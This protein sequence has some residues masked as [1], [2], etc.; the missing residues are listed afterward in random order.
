MIRRLA[1]PGLVTVLVVGS[2]L[3]CGSSGGPGGDGASVGGTGPG[4]NAGGSGVGSGSSTGGSFVPGDDEDDGLA[5][6]SGGDLSGAGGTIFNGGTQVLTPDQVLELT[7]SECAGFNDTP[8]VFLPTLQLVV[9]Q[10]MS[11]NDPPCTTTGSGGGSGAGGGT[12]AGGGFGMPGGGCTTGGMYTSEPREGSKWLMSVPPMI[13]ALDA[14]P[15]EMSVGMLLFPTADSTRGGAECVSADS[16]TP[17][18]VLGAPGSAQRTA[19]ASALNDALLVYNTPTH[20]AY[21]FG[22]TESLLPYEGDGAKFMILLTD[23]APTQALG[24]GAPMGSSTS[25]T[26]PIL[27][28]IAE[29]AAQGI[30]TYILGSPGSEMNGQ[31]GED[32]RP[33]LSEAAKLGGTGPDG[34]QIDAAPYC[35][36]DMSASPDFATALADALGQV[37]T[38]V[39]DACTFKIPDDIGSNTETF[40]VG[41]TNL[42]IKKGDGSHVLILRDDSPGDCTEGWT[43]NGDQIVLCGTT[44]DSYKADASAEVTLSFGCNAIQPIPA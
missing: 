32:M 9:D 23:G 5:V 15:D 1:Y 34:C 38:G 40:D 39:V 22:L 4:P 6:G 17:V 36:F 35:H 29:A 11:M 42:I 16:M 13:A 25:P 14:F 28:E 20:D 2:V 43:L 41:L 12:G 21:H 27:D 8:D 10:S 7:D 24:C 33:F 18:A 30:K 37:T 44:C 19:L 26:Q 3:A 31:T